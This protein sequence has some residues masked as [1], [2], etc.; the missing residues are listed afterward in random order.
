M[1]LNAVIDELYM[2]NKSQF[3]CHTVAPGTV[4]STREHLSAITPTLSVTHPHPMYPIQMTPEPA[5]FSQKG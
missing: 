5:V 2:S 3:L 1:S 4:T